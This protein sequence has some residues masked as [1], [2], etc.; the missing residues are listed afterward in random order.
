MVTVLGGNSDESTVVGVM[1]EHTV[2]GIGRASFSLLSKSS[3]TTGRAV[4]L[5]LQSCG[6]A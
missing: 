5:S 2:V 6:L 1:D 3:T 4:A